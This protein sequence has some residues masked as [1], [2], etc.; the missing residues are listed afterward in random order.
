MWYSV[1]E[2]VCV[3]NANDFNETALLFLLFVIVYGGDLQ[4]QQQQQKTDICQLV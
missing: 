3:G 1:N 2:A 4:Q